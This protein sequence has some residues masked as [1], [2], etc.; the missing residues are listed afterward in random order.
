MQ[1]MGVDIV[2]VETPMR[3]QFNA[4]L[5]A[6]LEKHYVVVQK[7][8]K[9]DD[10]LWSAQDLHDPGSPIHPVWIP[11]FQRLA[12][13]SRIDEVAEDLVSG[14]YAKLGEQIE[15]RFEGMKTESIDNGDPPI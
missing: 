7:N 8:N 9:L 3:A 10:R 2:S 11:Y 5:E 1:A 4:W 6:T 15:R 14:H 12:F 13:F